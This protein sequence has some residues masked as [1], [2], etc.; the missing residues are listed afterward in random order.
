MS[1]VRIIGRRQTM[2]F[3]LTLV[4]VAVMATP[5]ALAQDDSAPAPPLG[6]TMGGQGFLLED[7]EFTP[8]AVPNAIGTL[9]LGIN[10][11]GQIV[12]VYDDKQ[13][14]SHGFVYERGRYRTIDHP[15]PPAPTQSQGSPAAARWTSTT[16]GKSPAPI[17]VRTTA[18]TASCSM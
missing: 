15:K 3:L 17:S 2:P 5:S 18:N 8:I 6:S 11:R 10:E 4:L 1:A 12:G 14:R 9:A 7:G 16:R 13:G